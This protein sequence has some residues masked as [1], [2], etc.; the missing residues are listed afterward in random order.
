MKPARDIAREGAGA[1]PGTYWEPRL[2]SFAAIV[3][4]G[5][6]KVTG[7]ADLALATLLGSCVAACICDPRAGIGG[8]NHFLLPDVGGG[9]TPCDAANAARYGVHA[10]EL[11]IDEIVRQGGARPRLQAKLFG[12]ANVTAMSPAIPVGE[13][14]RNFAF[15]FLRRAGI[16]VTAANLGGER[17]RWVFF[18]P[19]DNKVLVQVLDGDDADRVRREEAWLQ[20]QTGAAPVSGGAGVFR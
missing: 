11:L 13:R 17:A 14:N 4:P 12:G 5:D 15:D 19:A 2:N 20:H 7:R 16:P 1:A 18:T 8:L 9:A 10:M 6:F 3:T